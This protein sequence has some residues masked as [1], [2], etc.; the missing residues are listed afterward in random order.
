MEIRDNTMDISSSVIV[1]I[2]EALGDFIP[3]NKK[4]DCACR[5]IEI[6]NEQHL[7]P[8]WFDLI[9]GADTHLDAALDLVFE[10]DEDEV[11]EDDGYED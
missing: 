5:L 4:E 9:R 8:D 6:F 2:W 10:Q 1:E 11:E 3:A 7:E